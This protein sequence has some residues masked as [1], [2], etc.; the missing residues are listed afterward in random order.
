MKRVLSLIGCGLL[1]AACAN[2]PAADRIALPAAPP[3]GEPKS[4]EGM[5]ADALKLAY[6]VPAFTRIDGDT[7]LWRYD[8]TACRAFFFLYR[9]NGA[10]TVRHVETLPRPAGAAADQAC[11]GALRR[12]PAPVS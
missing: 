2:R 3:P 9:E 12:T 7:Q 6:G 5:T 11:L 4:T 10:L 1:L 8:G